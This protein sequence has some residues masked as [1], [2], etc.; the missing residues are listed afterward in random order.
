MPV[1]NAFTNAAA[2]DLDA[3]LLDAAWKNDTAG[4]ERLLKAGANANTASPWNGETALF[5]AAKH[6]NAEMAALLLAR[7]AD[8]NQRNIDA[9]TPLFGAMRG[10][11]VAALLLAR[12]AHPGATTMQGWT[13]L[14]EAAQAKN[15]AAAKLLL[16][17]K[18]DAFKR[19]LAG[20]TPASIAA[21][22]GGEIAALFAALPP[23]QP[24]TGAPPAP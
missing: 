1:S 15:T 24:K 19:D 5:S 10:E 20:D 23:P 11:K 8:P 22:H 21:K 2:P 3:E 17:Y 14:H 9:R 13:P 4:V 6:D 12:G 16:D 18:A 7:D